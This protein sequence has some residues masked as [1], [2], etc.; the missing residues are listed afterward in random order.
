MKGV[1]ELIEP[2]LAPKVIIRVAAVAN[3]ALVCYRPCICYTLLGA[4]LGIVV[5][6]SMQGRGVSVG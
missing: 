1:G 2:S 3:V 4:E 5:V 6:K